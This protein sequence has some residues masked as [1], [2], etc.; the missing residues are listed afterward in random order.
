MPNPPGQVGK[1][2]SGKKFKKQK[3]ARHGARKTAGAAAR[4]LANAGRGKRV[5]VAPRGRALRIGTATPCAF[6]PR[7]RAGILRPGLIRR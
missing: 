6:A 2:K 5:L 1:K 3:Q 7:I 4:L